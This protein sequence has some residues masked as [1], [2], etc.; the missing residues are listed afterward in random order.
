MNYLCV[1]GGQT[2][3]NVALVDEEGTTLESWDEKPLVHSSR[4]GGEEKLRDVVCQT[5][6]EMR[7]QLRGHLLDTSL[8][9]CFSVTGYHENDDRIPTIVE[10]EARAIFSD[11][12]NVY[13]VPDYVGNWFAETRGEAGIVVISGGGSVVY[14]RN[15]SG[16]SLRIGGWG[17]LLGDEGSGY[18]IGLE[19]V[20]AALRSEAGMIEKTTLAEEIMRTFEVKSEI[21]LLH[22][23]YSGLISEEGIASIAPQ[24]AFCAQDG[25]RIASRILD[26]ATGYLTEMTSVAV[27][28]L[29]EHRIYLSGG[30]FQIPAMRERFE[31]GLT[32]INVEVTAGSADPITGIFF[33]AKKGL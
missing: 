6:E 19:A 32:S 12:E 17:H 33:V 31:K 7:R 4:P 11:F 1:D 25:D 16:I 24:V 29:G 21:Q 10:K 23:V 5:C 26:R 3:T 15:D 22:E 9:A 13:A 18:W 30:V 27:R 20:K 2:K 28:R 8:S 14:G